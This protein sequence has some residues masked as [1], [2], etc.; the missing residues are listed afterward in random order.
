M[1]VLADIDRKILSLH[2]CQK[3]LAFYYVCRLGIRG[4]GDLQNLQGNDLRIEA[5]RLGLE[6]VR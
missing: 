5:N 6:Y 2:G 3:H 4:G 1:A